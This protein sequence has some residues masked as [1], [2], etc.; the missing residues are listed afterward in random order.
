MTAPVYQ[1]CPCCPVCRRTDVVLRD[2][3]TLRNHRSVSGEPCE[4][5]RQ[6]PGKARKPKAKAVVLAR[7]VEGWRG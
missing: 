6:G 1:P 4:G 5:S 2:D 3:G 7:D